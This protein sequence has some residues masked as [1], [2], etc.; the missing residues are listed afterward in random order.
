M[1]D[2]IKGR[3]RPEPDI[4]A[5]AR[6]INRAIDE[7]SESINGVDQVGAASRAPTPR[8]AT[9]PIEVFDDVLYFRSG[10]KLYKLTGV[11]VT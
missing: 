5:L 2:K 6:S 3:I 4:P 7:I 11:E 8:T 1:P 10:G 9:R